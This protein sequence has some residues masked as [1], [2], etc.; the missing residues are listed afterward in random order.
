MPG[1]RAGGSMLSVQHGHGPGILD[2]PRR[3]LIGTGTDSYFF[4]FF[5]ALAFALITALALAA[6]LAFFFLALGAS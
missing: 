5:F 2:M 4:F 1:T 6:G 3:G